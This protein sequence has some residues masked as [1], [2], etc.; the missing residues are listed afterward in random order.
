MGDLTLY[1]RPGWGSAITEA[2]LAWLGSPVTIRDVGDVFM[3]EAA[4]KTLAE[5]NPLAQL[6]TLV[7]ADGSVL[8]E[9]AAITLWL[10]ERA[11]AEG[12][13]RLAPD[14]GDPL[15][16][17][18]LR[19][20]IFLVANVYPTFTFADDPRRF[21]EVEAAQAP[22]RAS[23]D[24]YAKRLYLMLEWAAGRPWFLGERMTAIDIYLCVMTRWR[25]RREWFSGHAPG[26]HAI[27]EGLDAHPLLSLCGREIFQP[28]G[29]NRG[30][31]R[32]KP[33]ANQSVRPRT[34]GLKTLRRRA[35]P[36]AA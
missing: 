3:D 16:P 13:P 30:Q 24:A 33:R 29:P 14:P 27:A 20:L 19:W 21:V 26:L 12:R 25:P 17:A 36:P 2:Q 32:T 5:I 8:T 9:S 6:P 4:R 23:V 1:A 34:A 18:F 35:S 11:A 10:D 15:R 31:G 22:F 7:L 28:D